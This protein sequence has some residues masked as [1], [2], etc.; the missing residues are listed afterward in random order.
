MEKIRIIA[1]PPGQAPEWVRQAWVGLEIPLEKHTPSIGITLGARGG[2][3]HPENQDGYIVRL[4]DALDALKKK[5]LDAAQ[6]WETNP[7]AIIG[8]RLMFARRVCQL[9]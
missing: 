2:K 9:I 3:P 1:V 5:N 4:Q 6:W 7:V 8:G